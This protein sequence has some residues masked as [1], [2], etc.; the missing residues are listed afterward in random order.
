[1]HEARSA[2]SIDVSEWPLPKSDYNMNY[3][4]LIN[5]EAEIYKRSSVAGGAESCIVENLRM[6]L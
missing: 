3:L 1:M 4:V 5:Y 6:I 2:E